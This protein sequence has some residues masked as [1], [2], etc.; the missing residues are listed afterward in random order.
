MTPAL[1]DIKHLRHLSSDSFFLFKS[2]YLLAAL[3][4]TL[5]FTTLFTENVGVSPRTG[6][7]VYNLGRHIG[8]MHVSR[9][10]SVASSKKRLGHL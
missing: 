6:S 3:S 7:T 10:T 2:C 9:Q 5:P 1:R 8:N 4:G